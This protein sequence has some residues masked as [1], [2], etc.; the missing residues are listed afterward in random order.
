[1]SEP[2][3]ATAADTAPEQEPTEPPEQS[4]LVAQAIARGI[5]SYEAWAM[6][7]PDLM[8]RLES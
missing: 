5:P 2:T 7:I 3:P 6:T 4:D 1:M 8:T